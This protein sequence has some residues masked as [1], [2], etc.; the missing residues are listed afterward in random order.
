M[1]LDSL[2]QANRYKDLQPGFAAGFDFLARNDLAE[3]PAGRHEIDGKRVYAIVARG[4]GRSRDQAQLETHER[5]IDIQMVLSGIDEMGWKPKAACVTAATEYDT[6]KD[7]QFFA[8]APDTW[9]QVLPWQFAI[10][11]PQDAHLP[12]ISTGEI[13]KIV[14]KVA[15]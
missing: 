6:G 5:Y 3:L 7:L 13:H 14:V 9:F 11:Y 12:M 2:N 1:I 8:G 15:V 4:P 10:F